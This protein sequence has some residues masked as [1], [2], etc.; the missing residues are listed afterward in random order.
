MRRSPQ[1]ALSEGSSL[2]TLSSTWGW[3]RAADPCAARLRPEAPRYTSRSPETASRCCSSVAPEAAVPSWSAAAAW[4]M[5]RLRRPTLSLGES[6]PTKRKAG[7][8]SFR[9]GEVGVA[10][11]GPSWGGLDGVPVGGL[12][13]QGDQPCERQQCTSRCTSCQ[14]PRLRAL[15]LRRS[16]RTSQR[17][18]SR[19]LQKRGIRQVNTPLTSHRRVGRPK[20]SIV[21]VPRRCDRARRRSRRRASNPACA[22]C[23][24]SHGAEIHP[25]K[26]NERTATEAGS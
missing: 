13:N 23:S 10:M 16:I 18:P 21:A 24:P 20:S 15:K 17:M 1:T 7:S 12:V 6:Q 14:K 19:S 26:P 11:R 4:A 9:P 5:A 22:W 8:G 25:C 3:C 2:P